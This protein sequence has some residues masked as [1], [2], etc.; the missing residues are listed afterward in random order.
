MAKNPEE[1]LHWITLVAS[2]AAAAPGFNF[3]QQLGTRYQAPLLPEFETTY[4]VHGLSEVPG[5]TEEQFLQIHE[6]AG[7]PPAPGGGGGPS[8]GGPGPT[9][10]TNLAVRSAPQTAGEGGTP[11]PSFRAHVLSALAPA[12][13]TALQPAAR[14]M[15]GA[16]TG[17]S[18][19][20]DPNNS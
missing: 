10:P 3:S 11:Q 15:L 1:T 5:A 14:G 16:I 19:K 6:F 4:L 13:S 9:P 8:G 7:D 17:G 12:A 18:T 20:P 2:F